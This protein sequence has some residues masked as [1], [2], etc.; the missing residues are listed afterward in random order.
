M[1]KL[2]ATH[3]SFI[4]DDSLFV[5]HDKI[6]RIYNMMNVKKDY[7]NNL[8][9]SKK[10]NKQKNKEKIPINLGE[11]TKKIGF[12][13]GNEYSNKKF[14]YLSKNIDDLALLKKGGKNILAKLKEPFP[15]ISTHSLWCLH[16]LSNNKNYIKDLVQKSINYWSNE[17]NNID[18]I[19]TN[20]IWKKG[21][22]TIEKIINI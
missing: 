8:V 19:Y 7:P 1:I 18:Y 5:S 11:L 2:L 17:L 10:V 13:L 14:I 6:K 20:D 22:D 21:S 12:E 16:Y 9:I 4:T 3:F 15:A